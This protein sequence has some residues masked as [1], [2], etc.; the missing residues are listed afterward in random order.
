MR[1]QL[2]RWLIGATVVGAV[3]TAS[4][5]PVE[6]DHRGGGGVTVQGGVTVDVP[7]EAPPPVREE[8][9]RARGRAGFQWQSG[10]WDWSHGKWEWRA[11]HWERE[12]HGKRWREATWENRNGQWVKVDGDWIAA[13]R[14]CSSTVVGT[15][16]PPTRTL[17]R[18][19]CAKK[20]GSPATASSTSAVVGIG[21][22][23]SGLGRRVTTSASA[24]TSIGAKPTGK[25]K[26]V[27]G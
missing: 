2:Y 9:E 10:R 8:P 17:H 16:R 22:T 15:M 21:A 13:A 24:R 11:G 7:R 6:R 18:P 12:R 19:R 27:R 5:Q 1:S 25:T 14:S 4:A 26:A 23:A 20:S 3:S